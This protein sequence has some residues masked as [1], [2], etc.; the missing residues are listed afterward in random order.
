[1]AVSFVILAVGAFAIAPF[2]RVSPVL[3]GGVASV[4][5][6]FIVRGLVGFGIVL[7]VFVVFF[8]VTHLCRICSRSTVA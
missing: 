6:W 2:W 8:G 7:L 1:M 3:L 4:P 5:Y